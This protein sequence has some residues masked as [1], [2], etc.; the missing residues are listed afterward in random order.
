MSALRNEPDAIPRALFWMTCRVQTGTAYVIMGYIRA[1][2]VSRRVS[3]CCPQLVPAK[4]LRSCSSVEA[5]AVVEVTWGATVN[6]GFRKTPNIFGVLLSWLSVLSRVARNCLVHGGN[7]VPVN[8]SVAMW[9][10][11]APSPLPTYKFLIFRNNGWMGMVY[12]L[13]KNRDYN[14]ILAPPPVSTCYDNFF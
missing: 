2:Y 1:P 9:S 12:V 10:L 7:R 4:A 3:L 11:L 13:R 5:L 14:P 8:L 6:K